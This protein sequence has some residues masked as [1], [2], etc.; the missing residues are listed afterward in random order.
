MGQLDIFHDNRI[1]VRHTEKVPIDLVKWVNNMYKALGHNLH[2]AIHICKSPLEANVYMRAHGLT[3]EDKIVIT[4]RKQGRVQYH[5]KIRLSIA[6]EVAGLEVHDRYS[7][8]VATRLQFMYKQKELG[9]L[10]GPSMTYFTPVHYVKHRTAEADHANTTSASRRVIKCHYEISKHIWGAWYFRTQAVFSAKPKFVF[11]SQ[12]GNTWRN[13]IR[14]HNEQGPAIQH[15]DGF[16][17]YFLNGVSVPP[18]LVLTS[19]NEL[20]PIE[21]I[22]KARNAEVRREAV[23]KIGVERMLNKLHARVIDK[24]E[25]YELLELDMKSDEV[26][27]RM[28]SN[29]KFLKMKNPSIHVYH[30]EGVPFHIKTVQE[31][32]SWRIG[33]IA[34]NPNQLT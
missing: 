33:G 2:P 32:L 7:E 22:L 29:P 6:S 20:N 24:W 15:K 12:G 4:P 34:W 18:S 10:V 11:R 16:N 17:W 1:R 13:T 25:E 31:A 26:V 30:V 27:E 19:A 3:Q 8:L 5:N 9:G 14:F 21:H 23:R 28:R